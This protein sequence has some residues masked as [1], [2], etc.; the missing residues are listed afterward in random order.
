MKSV[1]KIYTE[2]KCSKLQWIV[3]NSRHGVF[4]MSQRM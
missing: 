3:T 1:K 2:T 4:H